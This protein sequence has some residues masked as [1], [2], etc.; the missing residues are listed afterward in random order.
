[1]KTNLVAHNTELAAQLRYLN[2]MLAEIGDSVGAT[3]ADL[4]RLRDMEEALRQ[5]SRECAQAREQ[6]ALAKAQ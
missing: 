5:A 6:V 3:D 4:S 1:M 2:E